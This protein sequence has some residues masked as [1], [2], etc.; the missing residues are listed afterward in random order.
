[1]NKWTRYKGIAKQI[2]VYP[3]IG[4]LLGNKQGETSD[5][6]NRCMSQNNYADWMKPDKK[7]FI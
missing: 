6:N 3:Y 5:I 7:K 1:M 4:I 2:V